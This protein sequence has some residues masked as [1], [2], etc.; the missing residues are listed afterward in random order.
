MRLVQDLHRTGDSLTLQ[1]QLC[2]SMEDQMVARGN[3][4]SEYLT[5]NMQRKN[6]RD[7]PKLNHA[8]SRKSSFVEA[9]GCKDSM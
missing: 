5:S 9:M 6:L 8:G 4:S 7:I 2:Q 1:S 3:F